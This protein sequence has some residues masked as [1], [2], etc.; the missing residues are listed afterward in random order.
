MRY[1]TVRSNR[2]NNLINLL[3]SEFISKEAVVGLYNSHKELFK[4]FEVEES[5]L[6]EQ[7]FILMSK[8]LI[9]NK[10]FDTVV[11]F[12]NEYCAVDSRIDTFYK[13]KNYPEYYRYA[14][15]DLYSII[16]ERKNKPLFDVLCY[17]LKLLNI[18]I[19]FPS[20]DNDYMN[21]EMIE[22]HLIEDDYIGTYLAHKEYTKIIAPFEKY[23]DDFKKTYSLSEIKKIVPEDSHWYEFCIDAFDF[24]QNP[25][26][27][28]EYCYPFDPEDLGYDFEPLNVLCYWGFTWDS[29][30]SYFQTVYIEYIDFHSR[31]TIE[32]EPMLV[33]KLNEDFNT[34]EI[35]LLKLFNFL[36]KYNAN[37]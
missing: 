33:C 15:I 7:V 3:G 28:G 17:V 11:S 9:S 31:E 10:V 24:L 19:P 26:R 22:E 34:Q 30:G 1:P 29:P 8:H 32:L 14:K 35:K 27:I 20:F 25:S 4:D 12:E 6:L 13:I 36:N 16:S 2:F 18:Y 23:I 37:K 21:I 5:L